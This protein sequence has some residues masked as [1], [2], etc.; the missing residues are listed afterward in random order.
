MKSCS[1]AKNMVAGGDGGWMMPEATQEE[2]LQSLHRR[3]GG[4]AQRPEAVRRRSGRHVDERCRAGA[5]GR[6]RQQGA[7]VGRA[8]AVEAVIKLIERHRAARPALLA[9][10]RAGLR[11]VAQ[12]HRSHRRAGPAAG[13]RGPGAP[14]PSG[15]SGIT[16]RIPDHDQDDVGDIVASARHATILVVRAGT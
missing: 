8:G 15:Y 6:F 9:V 10:G 5:P 16:E 7:Q 14:R 1:C 4:G 3:P 2:A 12:T 13:C 11:Q